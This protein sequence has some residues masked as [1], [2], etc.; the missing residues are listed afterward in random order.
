MEALGMVM[1]WTGVILS[2]LMIDIAGRSML[3]ILRK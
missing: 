1:L 2:A 3:R